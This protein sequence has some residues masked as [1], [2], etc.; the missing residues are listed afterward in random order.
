MAMENDSARKVVECARLTGIIMGGCGAP[1]IK[2]RG[3]LR[4]GLW[5]SGGCGLIFV[6]T[7]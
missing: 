2:A 6:L 7:N 5:V 4:V 1:V 3:L